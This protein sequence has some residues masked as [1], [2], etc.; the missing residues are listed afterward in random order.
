MLTSRESAKTPR[1]EVIISGTR[2]NLPLISFCI[3]F[4]LASDILTMYLC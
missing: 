2:R 4:D 3:L 1:P